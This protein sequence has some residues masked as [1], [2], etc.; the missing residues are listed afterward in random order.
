MISP[1][2]YGGGQRIELDVS[3]T[4]VARLDFHS[5]DA[6]T[7]TDYDGRIACA[8]GISTAAGGGALTYSAASHT[9]SETVKIESLTVAMTNQILSL[10]G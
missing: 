4:N 1:V 2:Y 10:S 9:F 5:Y 7:T 8:G 6:S 3:A